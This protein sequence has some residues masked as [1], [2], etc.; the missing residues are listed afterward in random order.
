[1]IEVDAM[2]RE[3]YTQVKAAIRRDVSEAETLIH[4]LGVVRDLERTADL[5]TTIANDVIYLAEG[6]I[7][8]HHAEDFRTASDGEDSGA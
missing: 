1:M 2:N 6:E 7:V 3:M 8:R 4:F 5:A